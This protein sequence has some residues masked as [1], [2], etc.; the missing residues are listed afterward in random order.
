MQKQ[1]EKEGKSM[2]FQPTPPTPLHSDLSRK[3]NF[4]IQFLSIVFLTIVDS[5]SSHHESR[6]ASDDPNTTNLFI[7]TIP[8]SVKKKKTNLCSFFLLT[9]ICN[10][11]DE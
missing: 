3:S 11:L 10:D 4:F 2:R 7:S 8:R 5:D 9:L 6:H 1:R